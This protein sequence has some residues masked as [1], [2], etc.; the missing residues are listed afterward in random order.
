MEPRTVTRLLLVR[1]GATTLSAEDR[2]A[3]A[4]DPELS[5]LG[6]DQ[7]RSLARRLPGVNLDAIYA[8]PLRRAMET[9]RL[10]V[11]GR[12]LVPVPVP[13]LREISHGRWEER[14]REEVKADFPDEYA[15]W[16]HDPFTFAPEGGESGLEVLARAV[17]AVLRILEEH[18]GGSVI[19]VS[20]K[21]TI[22]LLIGHLLGF[23]LRTYRDRLDQ[24][25]AALNILDV[26]ADGEARLVLYNDVSHYA[27]LPGPTEGH[28]SPWWAGSG[29]GT[30]SAPRSR[31]KP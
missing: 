9:A 29:P 20:H 21:A 24:S 2:F 18:P 14:T 15:R 22:R 30:R 25:P 5:D 31:R 8:S 28:L 1:H 6:R 16:E 19:L 3:G 17:P 26:R 7:A 12:G 10:L 23:D 27:T 4:A 11:E 13:G